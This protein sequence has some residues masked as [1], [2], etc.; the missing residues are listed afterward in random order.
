[1]Y[2]QAVQGEWKFERS[3]DEEVPNIRYTIQQ[4][5]LLHLDRPL[6]ETVR[7]IQPVLSIGAWH[8]L[9]STALEQARQA[10][11][12]LGDMDAEI[13][14]L[15]T[16][17]NSQ[18]ELGNSQNAR[19]TF[20]L[21]L[22]LARSAGRQEAMAD[23]YM[24]MG[25]LEVE[26]GFAKQAKTYFEESL[27]LAKEANATQI[28]GKVKL[29]IGL[30]LSWEGRYAEAETLY[31]E[32]LEI[33]SKFQDINAMAIALTN[34]G[35]IATLQEDL[36]RAEKYWLEGLS[37]ARRANVRL[38]ILTLL[39]NIGLLQADRGKYEDADRSFEEAIALTSEI[40]SPRMEGAVRSLFGDVLRKQKRFDAALQQLSM[41]KRLAHETGDLDRYGNTLRYLGELYTSI[42]H[43]EEA[44]TVLMEAMRTAKELEHD[45]LV[46]DVLFSQAKL[47][48]ARGDQAE[49]MQIAGN[50]LEIHE[51]LGDSQR[52][53]ILQ[54]WMKKPNEPADL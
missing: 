45:I 4:A 34:L 7:A 48:F 6:V 27:A 39:A 33:V 49:S 36:E 42:E 5:S 17:A 53:G 20:Q 47:M 43:F 38:S 40:H 31:Q 12:A 35:T 26:L 19:E 18:Q 16:L 44:D 37:L 52:V 54:K 23:I 14:F 32:S 30:V 11:Q 46:G 25:K 15:S 9:A 8:S 51:R 10:A 41:S 21:A 13:F 22:Q 29:N 3:L 24:N 50:A 2:R 28:V 1:M